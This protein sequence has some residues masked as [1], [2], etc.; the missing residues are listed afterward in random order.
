MRLCQAPL[1]ASSPAKGRAHAWL[2]SRWWP[3]ANWLPLAYLTWNRK[4]IFLLFTLLTSGINS[5]WLQPHSHTVLLTS[6]D[7]GWDPGRGGLGVKL[8][9]NV[10]LSLLGRKDGGPHIALTNTQP[11][12]RGGSPVP[13][14]HTSSI[15]TEDMRQ[16]RAPGTVIQ[17]K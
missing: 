6:G 11:G 17:S 4:Y 10:S 15:F 7:L 9:V 12:C 3:L 8:W 2:K 14:N 13:R 1:A 5:L 16:S